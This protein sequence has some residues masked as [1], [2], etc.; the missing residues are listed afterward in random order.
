MKKSIIIFALIAI[1]ISA[2]ASNATPTPTQ[3]EVPQVVEATA[4]ALPPT[5]TAS[6]V[7]PSATPAPTLTSTPAVTL[8]PTVTL[9]ANTACRMGP[10]LNYYR[11][12]NFTSGMTTQVQGRSDD[13]KWL[14]VLT[15]TKNKSFTCW[16]PL[17]SVKAF[18]GA[19]D[20][21]VVPA[22]P[23]PT[24]AMAA[25][26]RKRSICGV[27]K[28]NGSVVINWTPYGE[29]MGFIIYRNGKNVTTVYGGEYID[30]DTP[31]SKSAYVLT[32]TIQ[33][34]NS[35]GLSKVSASVSVPICD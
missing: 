8:F 13:S 5:A 25:S 19:A 30:H 15:Q 22:A 23:L 21:R 20:L 16:I 12:T 35:V 10:D 6:P 18:E 32:Y 34:F 2:C 29:G 17:E 1:L 3:A 4:T 33:A 28:D 31:A 24:G 11:V 9:S 14:N 27:N 26:A 7:P